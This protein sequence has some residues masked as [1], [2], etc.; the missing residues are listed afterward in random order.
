[1]LFRSSGDCY[2]LLKEEAIIFLGDLGFFQSPPF[3]PG[4]KPSAWIKRLEQF[5]TSDIQ[6]FVPG[7]GSLGS[8][9]DL[10]QQ[11]GYIQMVLEMV[12]KAHQAGAPLESL[13]EEPLPAPYD[14]WALGSKRHQ[15]NLRFLYEKEKQ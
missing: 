13:F 4:S 12:D 11:R 3:M 5:E 15:N 2:L 9:A 7:H 8:K 1:M 10:Q 6:V 14:N